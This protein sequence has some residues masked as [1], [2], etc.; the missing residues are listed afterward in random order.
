MKA[1]QDQEAPV[2]KS[3]SLEAPPSI[4]YF[5]SSF[6][7]NLLYRRLVKATTKLHLLQRLESRATPSETSYLQK[8]GRSSKEESREKLTGSDKTNARE[9]SYSS[10]TSNCGTYVIADS[11]KKTAELHLFDFDPASSILDSDPLY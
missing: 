1:S 2:R 3:N 7:I 11:C 9:D 4:E 10:S 6:T 5:H 8:H